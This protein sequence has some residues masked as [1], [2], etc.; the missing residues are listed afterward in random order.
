MVMWWAIYAFRSL[1]N[2]N[3]VY[4]PHDFTPWQM[5][6]VCS[7]PMGLAHHQQL[8]QNKYMMVECGTIVYHKTKSRG[9]AHHWWL[10]Q[11]KYIMV[12]C[13]ITI[14]Y[15]TKARGKA[16]HQQLSQNKYIMV[17]C[18]T[19]IYHKTKARFWGNTINVITN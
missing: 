6:M 7:T 10:S 5:P 15:K 17:G 16:Q 12:E 8:S 9:K 18:N 11:N 2:G 1:V 4:H 19:T 3:I 14:Y 13:D